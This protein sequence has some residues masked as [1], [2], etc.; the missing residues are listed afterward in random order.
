MTNSYG[1][2]CPKV[3]YP[4]T[5][6]VKSNNGDRK[7]EERKRGREGGRKEERKEGRIEVRIKAL[8]DGF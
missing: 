7:K 2:A 8:N 1:K 3:L 5:S 6:S 4:N